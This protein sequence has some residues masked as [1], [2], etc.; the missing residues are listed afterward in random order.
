MGNE[1][2]KDGGGA[3]KEDGGGVERPLRRR[4]SV[5]DSVGE[6]KVVSDTNLTRDVG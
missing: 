5:L 4:R 1:E 2:S 3:D 6:A